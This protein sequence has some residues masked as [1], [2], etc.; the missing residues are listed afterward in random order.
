MIK[1]QNYVKESWRKSVTMKKS[2]RYMCMVLIPAPL[3]GGKVSRN[4]RI[5]N[6]LIKTLLLSAK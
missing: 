1:I 2:Y 5:V 6:A 4:A 3:A